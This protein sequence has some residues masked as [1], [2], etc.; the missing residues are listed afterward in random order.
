MSFE[1]VSLWPKVQVDAVLHGGRN[2]VGLIPSY[3]GSFSVELVWSL[4]VSEQL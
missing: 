1:A 3:G 2:V 4:L